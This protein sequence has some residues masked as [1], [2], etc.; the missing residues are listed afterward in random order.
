MYIEIICIS[1]KLQISKYDITTF[2]GLPKFEYVGEMT[3]LSSKENNVIYQLTFMISNQVVLL[4]GGLRQTYPQFPYA[5][6]VSSWHNTQ[7]R[8]SDLF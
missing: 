6:M 3:R 8:S 7:V 4:Y 1:P 2:Q 5:Y